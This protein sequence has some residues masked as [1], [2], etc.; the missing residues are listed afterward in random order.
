MRSSGSRTAPGTSPTQA[1]P[2]ASELLRELQE[3]DP[4]DPVDRVTSLPVRPRSRT[5][6][7]LLRFDDSTTVHPAAPAAEPEVA[8]LVARPKIEV[9]PKRT[10]V[11]GGVA[12][13]VVV[14]IVGL[15]LGVR[16]LN[17]NDVLKN[18]I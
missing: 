2:T 7:P 9:A 12:A 11:V 14:L 6:E 13:A 10:L 16:A 15:L 1:R 3:F 8:M 17:S 4:F 5:Q 18:T